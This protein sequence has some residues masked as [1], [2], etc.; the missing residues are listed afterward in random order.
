MRRLPGSQHTFLRLFYVL[1][2]LDLILIIYTFRDYGVTWDEQWH[3]TYGTYIIW[4]YTSLFRNRKALE[5]MTMDFYG[6]FFEVIAQSAARFSPFGPFETRHLISALFGFIGA[7]Y[8][9]RLGKLMAGPSAGL[10]SAVFLVLTPRFY[11]HS[12]F[13][14]KDIP[15]AVMYLVSVYYIIKSIEFLPRISGR[16]MLTLGI[17]IGLCIGIRFNGIILFSYLVL[18]FVLWLL[19]RR[20]PEPGS[21]GTMAKVKS[22]VATFVPRYL[23]VV[24]ISYGT[25]LVWWPAA[26]VHPISQPIKVLTETYNHL[27]TNKIVFEGAS[28]PV[29]DL[30]WYYLEKWFLITMPEFYFI[31]LGIVAGLCGFAVFRRR[32]IC[33]DGGFIGLSV[34]VTAALFPVAFALATGVVLYDSE[35][36]FLFI[37]PPLAVLA[38]V[39]V[40]VF[41]TQSRFMALKLIVAAMIVW[42]LLATAAEMRSLH[43]Y[44]YIYFNRI[45]GGGFKEGAKFYETDYWGASYKEGAEWVVKNYQGI[46]GRKVKVAS[47][48]FPFST[49][50]YLPNDRFEYVGSYDYLKKMTGRH[51]TSFLLQRGG[52]AI[53]LFPVV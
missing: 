13:N 50:Y 9:F 49:E 21:L 39:P 48:S 47:C 37:V 27:W 46:N 26:Q 31:A 24:S 8:A 30:P 2:L 38:A 44:E 19:V 16:M 10:L 15:F 28:V 53:K 20:I 22:A 33:Q 42:S 36:H 40:S 3:A 41:L 43:P 52:I 11:G 4:W 7:A 51:L 5:Y 25:A 45:F 17:V 14:N 1:L 29:A 34:L 32:N 18:G 35:R 6:G 12:F 23:L